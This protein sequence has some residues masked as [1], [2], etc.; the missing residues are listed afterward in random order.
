M[1]GEK[2]VSTISKISSTI[3]LQ[4]LLRLGGVLG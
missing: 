1:I 2:N 3:A 4:A